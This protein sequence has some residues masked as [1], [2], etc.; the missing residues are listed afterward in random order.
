MIPRRSTRKM[1][2]IS[3]KE[4]KRVLLVTLFL[5]V[6]VVVLKVSVGLLINSLSMIA[7]GLHSL[8]D[9]ISNIVGIFGLR[10][11]K[12]P[13]DKSHPYGHEKFE[14][15]TTIVIAAFL[16][17]V[18]FELLENSFV[19]FIENTAPEITFGAFI[20]LTF[21]LLVNV[22]VSDYEHRKGEKHGSRILIADSL[23]TRSDVFVTISVMVGFI[24]IKAGYPIAD[25]ILAIIIAI[26]IAYSGYKIIKRSTEVL[27]DASVIDD[28]E[29]G[30]IAGKIKGVT[31]YHKIRT[32]TV[33]E[34]IYVDLHIMTYGDSTVKEG[35][36]VAKK[37]EKA[38]RKKYPHVKDVTIHVDPTHRVV[39]P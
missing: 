30:E 21:T 3:Y 19:R 16:L 10:I 20:V 5:N 35:H 14:T 38:I 2:D 23:H 8:M 12:R 32:R 26:F 29:I 28:E 13:A 18:S 34:E 7:D 39:R 27:C 31:G 25:P 17:L 37:V 22:F 33:G 24:V 6:I 1:D 36:A 15:L 11:S 9:S 4:T